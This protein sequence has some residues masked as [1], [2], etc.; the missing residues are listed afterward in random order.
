MQFRH[1]LIENLRNRFV[2]CDQRERRNDLLRLDVVDFQSFQ[3]PKRAKLIS[4]SKCPMFPTI[5]LFTFTLSKVMV[6]KLPVVET[7]C[8]TQT[9]QSQRTPR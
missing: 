4:L 9:R 8:G 6:L 7:K 3:A 1:F 5:G 2:H